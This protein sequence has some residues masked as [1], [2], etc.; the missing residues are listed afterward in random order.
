MY[1]P[2]PL[3]FKSEYDA[4]ELMEY[5]DEYEDAYEDDVFKMEEGDEEDE[6]EE[7]EDPEFYPDELLQQGPYSVLS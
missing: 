3:A 5:P 7:D 2:V 1:N 4:E 6:D